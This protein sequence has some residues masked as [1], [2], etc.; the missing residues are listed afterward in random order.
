[1]EKNGINIP[2]GMINDAYFCKTIKAELKKLTD[3]YLKRVKNN[4]LSDYIFKTEVFCISFF[5]IPLI[6]GR[7]VLQDNNVISPHC[8][9]A[10][11]IL[12]AFL[13]LIFLLLYFEIN[14][15]QNRE[16]VKKIEKAKS[17]LS[18]RSILKNKKDDSHFNYLTT[19]NFIFILR[20][21]KW[22]LLPKNLLIKNDVFLLHDGDLVPCRCV[23]YNIYENVY[24]KEYQRNEVFMAMDKYR[25]STNIMT[26]YS[27]D[28]KREYLPSFHLYAFVSYDNA[29]IYIIRKY[30]NEKFDKSKSS[31]SKENLRNV[32]LEERV[33]AI[34]IYIWMVIFSLSTAL[35]LIYV[36]NLRKVHDIPQ[37]LLIYWLAYTVLMS[38][39]ILPFIHRIFSELIYGYC[40]SLSMSYETYFKDMTSYE[41][42]SFTSSFD[43]SSATENSS[44]VM[45]KKFALFY[46]LKSIFLLIF[47]GIKIN[48]CYLNILSD[49]SVLCFLDSN[50]ILV[51]ANHSVK[52][53]CIYN[54]LNTKKNVNENNGM[55]QFHNYYNNMLTIID[56]FMD[57][58][59]MYA[60]QRIQNIKILHSL[61][62]IS[63]FT[64][65]LKYIKNLDDFQNNILNY[66]NDQDYNHLYTCMC[67]IGNI[68]Y[69]YNKFSFR[70]LFFCIE[71]KSD[72]ELYKKKNLELKRNKKAKVDGEIPYHVD[73]NEKGNELGIN[74]YDNLITRDNFVF[75]FIL[76][77]KKKNKYHM[78][79]KGQLDALV[80]KC[81]F[82]YDGKVIKK[83][84]RRKKKVLKILNM[85]WISSGLESICF[86]YRPLSTDE[87]NY[88]K[89]NF[90]KN[91][92]I[93]T[94]NKRKV[95]NIKN[96]YNEP[97]FPCKENERFLSH[98]ISTS[99]FIGNSAV[100]ILTNNDIQ[101][102]IND[103]Y[104]AGIRF[105]YFSTKDQINT[106][107][108]SN[109]LGMETNWNT[110]ISLSLTDKSSFR[111]RDGKVVIPSGINNIKTHI[112]E[113]DDIPLR[114]SSYSGCNQFNTAEMIKILL[115]NNEIITCV[116]NSLNCCNF[117]L[118][119]LC[120]YSISVLLPYNNICSDCYGKKERSN[121]FGRSAINKNPL[122]SYSSFVN[123]FPCNLT[124]E[125]NILDLSEN[126]MELVYKLLKSSRIYKKNLSIS[127]FYF[128][129]Y[130]C[131]LSFLLFVINI[132]FLP[133]LI[134][135]WD[136]LLLILFI[137]PILSIS[138]LNN[139]NNS[140]I[141]NDI[142]DKVISIDFLV[143][144][145]FF[146]LIRWISFLTFSITVS[147][148]YIHILNDTFVDKYVVKGVLDPDKLESLGQ[149]FIG[150]VIHYCSKNI[151]I[152]SLYKCNIFMHKLSENQN[153]G[154]YNIGVSMIKQ[155]QIFF[156][157]SFSL[158]FFVSSLSYSDKYEALFKL[159]CIQNSKSYYS[160]LVVY[161]I[162]SLLYVAFRIYML[163]IYYIKQYPDTTL[164]LLLAVFSV[165]LL[166]INETLKR[167]EEK[168][169][170]NR[171]KYLKVLFGTR[172]GMW[173]PK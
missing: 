55:K 84:K 94:I 41:R 172:L 1:M 7:V 129:F 6:A 115:E 138:L 119:K 67:D 114:V 33:R 163:P 110:S 155:Y 45:E 134:S 3:E 58:K 71:N 103:F 14:E 20:N 96:F 56:I 65:L 48:K 101:A 57:N 82:Y 91:I 52:E 77:E 63:Y 35:M 137:I 107:N 16:F 158:F 151:N 18:V 22:E 17:I 12:I 157:F 69:P 98:L 168:I 132:F 167:I 37:Y 43:L 97:N 64:Q 92:Y 24:G 156:F 145:L 139:N 142:P 79:F 8:L 149:N 38:I 76:Y 85:Q 42:K 88:L 160:C 74:I 126:I 29:S 13:L 47:K 21:N 86:A 113:V 72:Y 5:F 143:K 75:I 169:K 127:M 121:P 23:E 147:V 108:T 95:Y 59:S 53:I 66:M 131:Y 68:S 130:Y 100:K 90:T 152:T 11:F 173:S 161:L 40:S 170:I 164:I 140:T 106:R 136:Y 165:I 102:R 61:F 28:E 125:K 32:V 81:M 154:A 34:F 135:V 112:Q 51:N 122:I 87:I 44:F 133:P 73:K 31:K 4:F 118:Y 153:A 39:S 10:L 104:D 62:L 111:N 27:K 120:N 70:M 117:E 123:S 141:M 150:D 2:V 60:Y 30:I 146:F 166:V 124:I 25:I 49:C 159:S 171:Q 116:G 19:S 148:Y 26:K 144:K 83:L 9:T 54:Q 36:S 50:G 15:A 105:V 80:S 109:T 89:T 93:L 128:Y 46:T 162:L 78:F 99:I